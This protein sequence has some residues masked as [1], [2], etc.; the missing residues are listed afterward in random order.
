MKGGIPCLLLN[1]HKLCHKLS[2][3]HFAPHGFKGLYASQFRWEESSSI[4]GRC[5]SNFFCLLNLNLHCF[6]LLL[7]VSD[8]L[9]LSFYS[10]QS[11]AEVQSR[12]L[13][14]FVAYLLKLLS[15]SAGCTEVGDMAYFPDV[16]K[17]TLALCYNFAGQKPWLQLA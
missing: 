15:D 4:R 5:L 3:D 16:K 7:V 8:H 11:L 1:S 12:A 17:L 9:L 6:A 13:L 2:Q 14:V 10:F